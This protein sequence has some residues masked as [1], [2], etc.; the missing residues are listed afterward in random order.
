MVG[1]V[2]AGRHSKKPPQVIMAVISNEAEKTH[3]GRDSVA[4]PLT[5]YSGGIA[6][7]GADLE[8]DVS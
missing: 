6:L 2:R 5:G 3:G 7:G 1:S 4:S 8:V